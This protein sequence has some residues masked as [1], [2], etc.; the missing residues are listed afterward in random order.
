M[1]YEIDLFFTVEYPCETVL[2]LYNTA[3]FCTTRFELF[4]EENVSD[5]YS[6]G[7]VFYLLLG[8]GGLPNVSSN[9][10]SIKCSDF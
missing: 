10:S 5:A 9:Q 2:M 8:Q 4:C 3:M 1:F 7:S 6:L